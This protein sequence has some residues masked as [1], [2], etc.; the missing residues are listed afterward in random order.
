MEELTQGEKTVG[1]LSYIIFFLPMLNGNKKEFNRFHANQGLLL[2]MAIVLSNII[3]N[4]LFPYL[5]S[6]LEMV[7]SVLLALILIYL[8][9]YGVSSAAKGTMKEFPVIGRLK[10]LN[11]G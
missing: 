3:N 1:A 5:P 11:K 4:Y 7:F 6:V 10:I 8:F 2:F 9:I